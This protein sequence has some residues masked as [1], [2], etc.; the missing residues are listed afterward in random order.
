MTPISDRLARASFNSDGP[1]GPRSAATPDLFV[2]GTLI[3]DKVVSA[4]LD[5][6]PA[7]EE[8]LAL[9]WRVAQLPGKPYPGLVRDEHTDARGRVYLDLSREEWVTLDAFEDP[10][11]AL[12]ELQVET[13]RLALAYVWPDDRLSAA[14]SVK[15]FTDAELRSYLERCAAW[16]DRYDA[17]RRHRRPGPTP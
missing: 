5:R 6:V 13:G 8:T 3:V 12:A 15:H 17:Q 11:Y 9:G 4:L 16:R 10:R 7:H 2:Y 14:W 1:Q